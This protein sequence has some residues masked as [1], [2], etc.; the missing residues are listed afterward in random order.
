MN[1]KRISIKDYF[2]KVLNG[3]A[4]GLFSSLI[5]GLILKQIGTILGVEQLVSFGQIA[6][7]LMGPAIG[8]GVAYSL[9]V[10]PLGIF[11][12][13]VTG[14]IGAGTVTQVEGSFIINVGEPVGALVASLIGAEVSRLIQ[15]RTKVDIVLVPALSIMAGGFTGIYLAPII[16]NFM[17]VLGEVINLAT[18]QSPIPMGILVSV[19][20]GIILTLPISSAAIAIALGLSG[21]AAGASTVGCSSQMIGFAIA[22]FRENGIGGFIAQGFG[23]SMIQISNIVKNPKIFIPPIITSAILGPI[24]TVVFKMEG[25]KVGA[26]MGTSGLVGQF[27]TYDAMGN[28][29]LVGIA[30][31]HF[32][33]P[34]II[35]FLISEFMRKKGWIKYGDMKL[36]N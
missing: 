5:I 34:A 31:L 29:G 21:L 26:G 11:A 9:Q 24:S 8:A 1:S 32:I 20:M 35:T 33:L 14:A 10:S 27:A 36:D 7:F 22:S 28:S 13:T 30:L 12:A 23:T 6:Q 16:S 3:M 15:G 19:L 17:R 4:L 18:Q 2:I 25:T